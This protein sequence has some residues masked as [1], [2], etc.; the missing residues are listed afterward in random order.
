MKRPGRKPQRFLHGTR[1]ALER[2]RIDVMNGV[3]DL[4]LLVASRKVSD[5]IPPV[6]KDE[7]LSRQA[8]VLH[9]ATLVARCAEQAEQKSS[10]RYGASAAVQPGAAKVGLPLETSAQ[11]EQDWQQRLGPELGSGRQD[12]AR[13]PFLPPFPA[14]RELTKTECVGG[15]LAY[16]AHPPEAVA[17]G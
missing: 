17:V 13:S 3:S 9:C 7:A 8:L 2:A 6:A 5:A 11:K 15:R 12:L 10:P 14:C 4:D 16:G 1:W